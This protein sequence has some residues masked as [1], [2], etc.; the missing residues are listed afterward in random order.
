MNMREQIMQLRI[1]RMRKLTNTNTDA[2]T[3]T[4]DWVERERTK[5]ELGLTATLDEIQNN[6]PLAIVLNKMVD[7]TLADLLTD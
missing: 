3:R 2:D 1:E 7:A 5:D 4:T 6:D